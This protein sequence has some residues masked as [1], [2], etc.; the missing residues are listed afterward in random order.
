MVPGAPGVRGLPVPR[1]P[2]GRHGPRPLGPVAYS[3][4]LGPYGLGA[5]VASAV[6]NSGS[7]WPGALG[8]RHGLRAFLDYIGGIC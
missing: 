4:P 8:L 2:M 5:S 1:G 6:W 7:G 3:G